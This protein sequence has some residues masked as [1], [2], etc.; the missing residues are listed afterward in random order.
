MHFRFV[1]HNI[2]FTHLCRIRRS[3]APLAGCVPFGQVVSLREVLEEPPHMRSV[4]YFANGDITARFASHY[5]AQGATLLPH[6]ITG[7][8]NTQ[9]AEDLAIHL[10]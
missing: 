2:L 8:L 5:F 9:L 7:K 6:W 1:L 4:L 3:C 10:G